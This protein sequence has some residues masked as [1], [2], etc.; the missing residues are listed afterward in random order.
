M[1]AENKNSKTIVLDA[2]NQS[3]GRIATLISYYLQDKHRPEY[4]P[5]K[6]GQTVVLVKNLKEMAFKGTKMKVKKYFKHTGYLGHLKEETLESLWKKNPEKVLRMAVRGMLPKN[7]LRD[8]RLKRLKI[9][10]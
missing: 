5:N 4:A 10:E 7:K 1:I 9:E 3:L 6:V 2:Q 8:K